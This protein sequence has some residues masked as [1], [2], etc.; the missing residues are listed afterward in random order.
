MKEDFLHYVWKFKKFDFLNICSHQGEWIEIIHPGFHNQNQAGPDFFNAKLRINNQLWAGNVEIHLKSSD[1][2]LHHHESDSAYDNVI[3]HVVWKHDME[4]FRKDNSVIPTIE[5]HRLVDSEALNRYQDLLNNK[6]SRWI[7]C[8]NDFP[9]FSDFEIENWL[10]RLFIERLEDKSKLIYKQLSLNVND[11]EATLFVLLAK[12]FGLNINGESFLAMAQNTPYP[13]I[14]K[15]DEVEEM[16]A[17]FFGQMGM[18]D[19]SVD[20]GYY[21]KLQQDY[22]YLKTKFKLQSA[23]IPVNYFRL[24]PQNFPTLRLAQLAQLYTRHKNLFHD[25]IEETDLRKI[26]QKLSVQASAFWNTHY[27]FHKEVQSRAKK[28]SDSFINLLLINTVVPLKFCYLKNRGE[29]YESLYHIMQQLP[30]EKNSVI[31]HFNT[32]RKGVSQNAL[33][34]QA[35]LQ[36]KKQYCDLNRCL[37]CQLGIKLLH[38]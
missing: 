32:I 11:W 34:A 38:K 4:V 23:Q 3:L 21:Q 2:Y 16:E 12:N 10:E 26:R 17:L 1:W 9:N 22:Q 31:H 18:L 29:P 8:E 13:I 20:N 37:Q 36:M 25:L 5:L 28:L 33:S 15:I 19:K 14:R 24:R 30:S 6:A 27:T 35:L 7:N